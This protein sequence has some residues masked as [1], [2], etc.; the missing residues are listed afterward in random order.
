MSTAK[1]EPT[2][3]IAETI[4]RDLRRQILTGALGP[5]ERLPG[6]RELAQRYKTNR[7]T[8]REAVRKLEQSR[9]ITVRHGQGVTVASFRDTGTMELLSPFLETAPD[10]PEV[11]RLLEDILPLRL[12]VIE[13]A[14]TMA[15]RRATRA[16]LEALRD[17]TELLISA[18]EKG[19]RLVIAH[20]FQRWLECV[21]GAG[22]SV[23]IRWVANPWLD[24]YRDLLERFPVL[25][26]LEPSFPTDLRD[27]LSALE[28]GDEGAAL[29]VLRGYYQ[30][31]DGLFMSALSTALGARQA[32]NQAEP[33]ERDG[34]GPPEGRQ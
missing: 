6:E 5:G 31:V 20:G 15:V 7:N 12:L 9:L 28:Q 8:L 1:P 16:D 25:W 3:N 11:Y 24:S 29:G 27:F 10:L 34:A 30:R 2:P 26:V 19:D 14:A 13:F 22:H 17:I 33:S 18:F 23:A 4:F 21:V 32:G